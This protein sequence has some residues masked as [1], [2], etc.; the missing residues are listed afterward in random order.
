MIPQKG[1]L[2]CSVFCCLCSLSFG[3]CCNK[4]N[5]PFQGYFVCRWL[6]SIKYTSGIKTLQGLSLGLLN[7]T[8]DLFQSQIELCWTFFPCHK[9]Y[10]CS[11]R[12]IS[13]FLQETETRGYPSHIPSIQILSCTVTPLQLRNAK[14]EEI[15][16]YTLV[17]VILFDFLIGTSLSLSISA[18]YISTNCCSASYEVAGRKQFSVLSVCLFKQL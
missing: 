11:Y 16:M 1:L 6:L 7:L 17:S 13:S 8:Q 9:Y 10:S 5:V 4:I 18:D 12:K 3:M 2:D 15:G 14:Y